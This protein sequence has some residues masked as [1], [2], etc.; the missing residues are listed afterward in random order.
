MARL[1]PARAPRPMPSSQLRQTIKPFMFRMSRPG[2][3]WP[4][5]PQNSVR[6]VGPNAIFPHLAHDKAMARA[7]LSSSTDMR[8]KPLATLRENMNQGIL[9]FSSTVRR[10]EWCK[11]PLHP[12]I[13]IFEL[14]KRSGT[15]P[16]S[17]LAL[18]RLAA[19]SSASFRTGP[20]Q[21]QLFPNSSEPVPN[22]FRKFSIS[23]TFRGEAESHH[24]QLLI[25][26]CEQVPKQVSGHYNSR[27]PVRKQV[28]LRRCRRK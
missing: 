11:L 19:S 9:L 12:N 3:R 10:R 20:E 28:S 15:C 8:R 7:A 23:R 26:R 21:L 17:E 1:S 14:R 24:E 4:E 25:K 5:R 16:G 6:G 18:N 13:S 27:G 2:L 22:P